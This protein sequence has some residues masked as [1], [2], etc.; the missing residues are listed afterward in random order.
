[1]FSTLSL[2]LSILKESFWIFRLDLETTA[3]LSDRWK[4]FGMRCILI[5]GAFFIV[6]MGVVIVSRGAELHEANLLIA[7]LADDV[8]ENQSKFQTVVSSD[9]Y[10]SPEGLQPPEEWP[11]TLQWMNLPAQQYQRP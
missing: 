5:I 9:S 8:I 3:S 11:E 2:V 10:H 1:M 6:N 7:S 4:L